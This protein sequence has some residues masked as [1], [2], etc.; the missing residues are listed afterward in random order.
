MSNFYYSLITNL[1]DRLCCLDLMVDRLYCNWHCP[2]SG[3]R[4]RL[5]LYWMGLHTCVSRP[6]GF[7]PTTTTLFE[8]RGWC[9]HHYWNC[10]P[11]VKREIWQEICRQSIQSIC[12]TNWWTSGAVLLYHLL[13]I[14]KDHFNL[15]VGRCVIIKRLCVV[16]TLPLNESQMHILL[17]INKLWLYRRNSNET[18]PSCQKDPKQLTKEKCVFLIYCMI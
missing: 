6:T 1:L 2:K 9:S 18:F 11:S 16:T 13:M 4:G 7:K 8:Q 17:E 3:Q 10:S 12:Q 14:R 5:S 15:I